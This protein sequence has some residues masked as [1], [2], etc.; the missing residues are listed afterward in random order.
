[1]VA[2]AIHLLLESGLT[3]FQLDIGHVGI[4]KAL[5]AEAG[6]DEE[7]VSQLRVLIE[8]KNYFGVEALVD[9]LTLSDETAKLL[10]ETAGTFSVQEILL[11]KLEA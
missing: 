5:V 4:F 3:D 8:S 6:M 1:M 2:L 11:L 10:F 9:K 7:T